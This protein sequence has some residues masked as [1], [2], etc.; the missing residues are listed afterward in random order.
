LLSDLHPTSA[1]CGFRTVAYIAHGP[2]RKAWPRGGCG[3]YYLL[4]AVRGQMP[5]KPGRRDEALDA[6]RTALAAATLEPSE[7]RI[8]RVA[9]DSRRPSQAASADVFEAGL[10]VCLHARLRAPA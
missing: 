5:L 2:G 7:T 10:R 9:A 8:S 4:S 3:D 6:W 1:D